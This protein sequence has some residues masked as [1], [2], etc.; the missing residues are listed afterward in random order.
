MLGRI[1]C[2]FGISVP[3][4]VWFSNLCARMGR[5]LKGQM[6]AIKGAKES[7]FQVLDLFW[8]AYR[9]GKGLMVLS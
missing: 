5:V 8:P 6:C 2:A 4:R 7:P 3:E 9:P 1:G